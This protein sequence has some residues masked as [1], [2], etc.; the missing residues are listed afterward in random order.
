VWAN[1]TQGFV[2]LLIFVVITLNVRHLFHGKYLD[3]RGH[4]IVEIYIYSVTWL[5]LGIALIRYASLSVMI[6]T[7]SKVVPVIQSF[8]VPRPRSQLIGSCLIYTKFVFKGKNNS[9]IKIAD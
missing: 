2:L 9:I 7:I 8:C 6:L 5:M 4:D 1:R 3:S